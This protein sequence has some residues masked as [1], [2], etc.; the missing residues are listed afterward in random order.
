MYIVHLFYY[1]T[2]LFRRRA[3]NRPPSSR[4][5]SFAA[6][7]LLFS[8][9]FPFAANRPPSSRMFPYAARRPLFSRICQFTAIFPMFLASCYSV[10]FI[11]PHEPSYPSQ[12]LLLL[13]QL[14]PQYRE[15][16]FPPIFHRWIADAESFCN[17]G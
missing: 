15:C 7:R 6:R 10:S 9:M 12:Q 1:F 3:A 11:S 2:S 4:I 5:F 14:F 17:F 13:H 16:L 8:R